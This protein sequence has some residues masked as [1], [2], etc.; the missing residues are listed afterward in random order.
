MQTKKR[1]K[2]D[3][4]VSEKLYRFLENNRDKRFLNLVGGAGSSKS[5]SIA[6]YL[7]FE[8]MYKEKDIRILIIR[9]TLPAL[10]ITAYQLMLDLLNAYQ[11]PHL[12]N[13]T[14]LTIVAGTNMILF[15]SLDDP[16]KIKSYEGN[17][18]WVEEA[19]DITKKD[20]MQLNLRTRRK[21]KNGIN[22]LF[23]SYNPISM[24]N[25]L[26]ELTENPNLETTA[27]S[28]T[29]YKDNPFLDEVYKKQLE[30]LK[31]QD[32]MYYKIYALGEWGTISNLIYSN[33]DILSFF[34][35]GMDTNIYGLD[36]GFNNPSAL[37]QIGLKDKEIYLTEKLYK[38]KLTNADL[39][40][41]LE[42]LIPN[43][44]DYIFADSA[45]PARIAEIHRAGFN[46]HPADKSVK[47][48]IDRC[49]RLK[50]HLLNTSVNLIKEREG[51]KYREDKDGNVIEEPVKF[52]DHLMDCWR[53]GLYSWF[54]KQIKS[55]ASLTVFDTEGG[56]SE[57]LKGEALELASAEVGWRSIEED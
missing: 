54:K 26:Y 11:M 45:E 1:T 40:G 48:G 52:R 33:C 6:Q 12:L 2:I 29:T 57:K 47:D 39:I 22:Q 28:K 55:N 38:R 23:F 34:P 27:V 43:K 41:E 8:K 50:T 21:N 20:F 44:N 24:Q 16:A 36:F 7:L 10:K 30:E 31:N 9:K 37:L 35:D 56:T 46:I 18:V 32:E 53:Y 4:E 3:V 19:T 17:Y 14:E 25:Y 51:Y 5:W 13:K 42:I 15:K 49:K